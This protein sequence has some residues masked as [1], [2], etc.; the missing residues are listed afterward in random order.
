M[1]F[2]QKLRAWLVE[3]RTQLPALAMAFVCSAT[4]TF[5]GI[6][7]ELISGECML[8]GL[9][10]AGIVLLFCAMHASRSH[11]VGQAFVAS[12][13]AMLA[14]TFWSVGGVESFRKTRVAR[15]VLRRFNTSRSSYYTHRHSVRSAIHARN[16]RG[17][18]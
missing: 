10:H 3:N 8:R 5:A 6:A 4:T 18:R 12:A 1:S 13:C 15:L 17:S 11:P 7:H 2:F 14:V 16:A 9:V